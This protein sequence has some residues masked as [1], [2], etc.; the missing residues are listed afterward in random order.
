MP[1][2]TN[3]LSKPLVNVRSSQS[4]GIYER[5]LSEGQ[6]LIDHP[7]SSVPL[8]NVLRQHQKGRMTVWERITYLADTCSEPIV[9]FQ[10]W[11]PQLDGASLVTALIKID[12]QDV[13][14]HT[15]QLVLVA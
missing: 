1:T 11:G 13:A 2:I 6:E 4:D 12:G 9:L 7:K 3:P 5:A 10:N 8:R 14:A 15:F